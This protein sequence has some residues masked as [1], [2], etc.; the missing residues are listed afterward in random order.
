LRFG[1]VKWIG[2]LPKRTFDLQQP[3]FD[4]TDDE[5]AIGLELV[6]DHD[7]QPLKLID[8]RFVRKNYH[9]SVGR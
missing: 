4:E 3:Y 2:R 7:N 5:D 1:V 6:C 9:H 8:D